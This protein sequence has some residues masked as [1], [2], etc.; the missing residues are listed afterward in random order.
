MTEEEI[1]N[2]RLESK[3]T[4]L[5]QAI[6]LRYQSLTIISGLAATLIGL[7]A[8]SNI[9]NIN[10]CLLA[11]SLLIATFTTV[12]ALGRYIFLTRQDIKKLAKMIQ[13]E[14]PRDKKFS[15]DYWVEILYV[16]FVVSAIL[17]LLALPIFREILKSYITQH[18]LSDSA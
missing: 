16:C 8:I 4:T 14:L 18:G 17:F 3:R 7:A 11:A 10:K 2:L 13:N 6:V 9:E 1:N 12:I 15:Q 5:I